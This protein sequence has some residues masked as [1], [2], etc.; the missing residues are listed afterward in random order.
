MKDLEL[1]I[2]KG[3]EHFNKLLKEQIKRAQNL[4]KEEDFV[5]Y[6]KLNTIKIAI[7]KGDGIGPIIT[8]VAEKVLNILLF[9]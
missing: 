4:E 8:S 3:Q 6:S 1:E 9:P 7:V 2:K 5:D